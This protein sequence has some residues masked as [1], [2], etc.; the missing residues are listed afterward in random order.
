MENGKEIAIE[1]ALKTR[2]Q[3]RGGV[4]SWQIRERWDA[5]RS[6]SRKAGKVTRAGVGLDPQGLQGLAVMLRGR[7]GKT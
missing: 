7:E 4:P 3:R 5:Y 2:R 1:D 6:V